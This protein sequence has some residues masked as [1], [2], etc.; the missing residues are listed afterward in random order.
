MS[1]DFSLINSR[2][3]FHDGCTVDILDDYSESYL[4]E[5]LEKDDYG[6]DWLHIKGYH[7]IQKYHYLHFSPKQ[8]A[9]KWRI[10]IYGWKDDRVKHLQQYT[11]NH[12]NKKILLI[13]KSDSIKEQKTWISYLVKMIKKYKCSFFVVSN[14]SEKL[15]SPDKNIKI[16]D[17]IPKNYQNIFDASYDIGISNKYNNYESLPDITFYPSEMNIFNANGGNYYQGKKN[18]ISDTNMSSEMIIKNILDL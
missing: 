16:V 8:Y 18:R 17:T 9:V 3:T 12:F 5:F 6:E 14:D 2:I 4:V 15:F 10:N 7:G 13:F 1:Q 11:Y